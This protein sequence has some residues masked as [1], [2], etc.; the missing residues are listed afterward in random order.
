MPPNDPHDL[1]GRLALLRGRLA[2]RLPDIQGLGLAWTV[3]DG[4]QVSGR[5]EQ[6]EFVVGSWPSGTDDEIVE[7]AIEQVRLYVNA[8]L[9]V[10]RAER[11]RLRVLPEVVLREDTAVLLNGH[12]LRIA[13]RGEAVSVRPRAA[14]GGYTEEDAQQ[15]IRRLATALCDEAETMDTDPQVQ[16]FLQDAALLLSKLIGWRR[17]TAG[18][19]GDAY[20]KRL[21]ESG[22]GD[23]EPVPLR[24]SGAV[25]REETETTRT[26]SGWTDGYRYLHPMPAPGGAFS[27]TWV[28]RVSAGGDDVCW[29][30]DYASGTEDTEAAAMAAADADLRAHGWTLRD[31]PRRSCGPVQPWDSARVRAFSD[32]PSVAAAAYNRSTGLWDVW[33]LPLGSRLRDSGRWLSFETREEA[34]PEIEHRY[35][36]RREGSTAAPEGYSVALGAPEDPG[37]QEP[38]ES[39]T[40][41]QEGPGTR[42]VPIFSGEPDWE[43]YRSSVRGAGDLP[44]VGLFPNPDPAKTICPWTED[45]DAMWW[46]HGPGGSAAAMVLESQPGTWRW[47]TYSQWS[48]EE[49]GAGSRP[50]RE[51]AQQE[52][53]AELRRWRRGYVLADGSVPFVPPKEST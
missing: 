28:S 34:D 49:W 11:F 48:E 20:A 21:W 3:Q 46:R 51:A 1:P 38:P 50:T 16:D 35:D 18:S 19:E 22:P 40:A 39:P 5:V 42:G 52:A 30:T 32:A 23:W 2:A 7:H 53:D 9:N 14:P 37:G 10:G 29:E 24:S 25:R 15:D 8:A 43:A 33:A 17:G 36:V 41:S 31:Q 27:D 44:E 47:T 6:D 26:A 12:Q 13:E 45:D 4:L